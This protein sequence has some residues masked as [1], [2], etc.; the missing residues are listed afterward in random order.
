M[1]KLIATFALI[2]LLAASP[3]PE[4]L[5][6]EE[7]RAKSREPEELTLDEK[8][9]VEDLSLTESSLVLSITT[10][11]PHAI[12]YL[13]GERYGITP[14]EGKEI[15]EGQHYFTLRKKGYFRY[16]KDIVISG[17]E[18]ISLTL[19]IV[20]I[21]EGYDKSIRDAESEAGIIFA[22]QSGTF[23]VWLH[24]EQRHAEDLALIASRCARLAAVMEERGLNYNALRCRNSAGGFYLLLELAAGT[25]YFAD[26]PFESLRI[27]KRY[28]SDAESN[29][30][31]LIRLIDRFILELQSP[32]GYT[33]GAAAHALRHTYSSLQGSVNAVYALETA[34]RI[35]PVEFIQLIIAEALEQIE[36]EP[37]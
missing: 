8:S 5:T 12:V 7:E 4:D 2:I 26:K 14:I 27:S 33:R 15:S 25:E 22:L 32:D 18:D 9:G 30:E 20:E 37:K 24:S 28:R 31:E 10:V 29:E 23:R 21:P 36:F 6:L 1:L 34:A 13:D 11:P 3:E 19:P 35:E 16:E 17:D